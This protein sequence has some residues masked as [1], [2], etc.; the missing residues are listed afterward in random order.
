MENWGAVD[1]LTDNE[2]LIEMTTDVHNGILKLHFFVP[3]N[4]IIF[5]TIHYRSR[6][7]YI[8]SRHSNRIRPI[9]LEPTIPDNYDNQR[10]VLYP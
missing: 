5:E 3:L 8:S 2:L 1:H 7:D 4:R 9:T 6:N 10:S